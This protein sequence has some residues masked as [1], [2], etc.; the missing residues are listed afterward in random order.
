MEEA[1]ARKAWTPIVV[2]LT[3]GMIRRP[4]ADERR[5][6][7]DASMVVRYPEELGKPAWQLVLY[8]LQDPQPMKAD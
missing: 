7:G 8:A 1:A 3:D 2:S 5:N 4:V 6:V